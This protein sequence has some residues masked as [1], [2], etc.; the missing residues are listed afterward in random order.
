MKYRVPHNAQVGR[1]VFIPY[2]DVLGVSHASGYSSIIIPG[3]GEP[4]FDAFEANPFETKKQRQEAEVHNLLQKLQPDSISLKVNLIG[5]IDDA[6]PDVKEKEQRELME[7][8]IEKLRK[9]D[10]KKKNKMR[11]KGK[12]GQEMGNKTHSMHEAMREKNKLM[13]KKEY[14]KHKKEQEML[15]GDI[16]FLDKIDEK[17]DPLE[18][19]AINTDKPSKRQKF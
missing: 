18:A 9:K 10:K 14:E 11:G 8:Q 12:I 19:Y 4:N 3:S 15:E 5:S 2:E 13:Y 6:A 7:Q 1:V 17:F 16:E